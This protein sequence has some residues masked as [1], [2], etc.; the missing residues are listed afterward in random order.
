MNEKQVRELI[1]ESL[2]KMLEEHDFSELNPIGGVLYDTDEEAEALLDEL[3][4]RDKSR[5]LN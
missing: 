2:R 3:K 5:I 4:I 1:R